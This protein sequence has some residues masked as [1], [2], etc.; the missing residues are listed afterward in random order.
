MASS[1]PLSA[2]PPHLQQQA[3]YR[4]AATTTTTTPPQ[5][6]PYASSYPPHANGHQDSYTSTPP[7]NMNHGYGQ[8]PGYVDQYQ[9]QQQPAYPGYPPTYSGQTPAT[10]SA[11]SSNL[12]DALASIPDEQKVCEYV[13]S[14][15]L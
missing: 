1:A 12:A 5:T 8:Q 10:M 6:P 15:Y 3:Q 2:V 14:R 13:F 9:Q 7:I 11:P 4:T